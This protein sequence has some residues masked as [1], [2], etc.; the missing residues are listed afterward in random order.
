[1]SFLFQMI[2]LL[3]WLI[4]RSIRSPINDDLKKSKNLDH[5]HANFLDFIG[6][7]R[8][9]MAFGKMM[10][11]QNTQVIVIITHLFEHGKVGRPKATSRLIVNSTT[12]V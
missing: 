10:Q 12:N 6:Q 4:L 7:I 11:D 8:E 2:T 9:H 1:M 3:S 5:L